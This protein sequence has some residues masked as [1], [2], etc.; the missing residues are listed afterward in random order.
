MGPSAS[1]RPSRGRGYSPGMIAR[2]A[3][4]DGQPDRFTTGHAYTYTLE[5]VGSVDG[6]VAGYH[7]SAPSGSLSITLWTDEAAMRAGEAAVGDARERLQLAGS[8][9]NRVEVFSVVNSRTP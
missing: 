1:P 3:H 9:P 2:I 6:F 5:A 8:P 7:L 4:F